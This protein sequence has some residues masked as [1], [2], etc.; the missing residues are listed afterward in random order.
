LPA[1]RGRLGGA[2]VAFDL[3]AVAGLSLLL[4]YLS[5]NRSPVADA[6]AGTADLRAIGSGNIGATNVLRTG[7]A[8]SRRRPAARR[9]KAAVAYLVA[10]W[11]AR[12]DAAGGGGGRRLS[13]ACHPVWLRFKGGKAWRPHRG[14]IV[15]SPPAAL[16]LSPSDAVAAL[17][18]YS[19]PPGF[20]TSPPCRRFR[21]WRSS[22]RLVFGLLAALMC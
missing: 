6:D 7:G 2:H 17:S 14:L 15:A 22:G 3:A 16:A 12:D 9:R 21:A 19:S 13:R 8:I 5:L 1:E 20:R 10:F 18:R 4:G 11:L